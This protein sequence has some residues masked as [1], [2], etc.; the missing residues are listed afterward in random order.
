MQE[1]LFLIGDYFLETIQ[2][3][4]KAI[5]AFKIISFNQ[6]A[7][8]ETTRCRRSDELIAD[9]VSAVLGS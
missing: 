1:R 3:I 9:Q 2:I 6:G 8:F 5:H 4:K 7:Q